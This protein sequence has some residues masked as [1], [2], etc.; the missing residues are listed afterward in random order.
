MNGDKEKERAIYGVL[1][2]LIS[3]TK[4]IKEYESYVEDDVDEQGLF[5]NS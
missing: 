3:K 4:S 1:I 5:T 2:A